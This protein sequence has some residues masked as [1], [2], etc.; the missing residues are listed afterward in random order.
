MEEVVTA[1]L[2]FPV[3]AQTTQRQA[4]TTAPRLL[5]P[6]PALVSPESEVELACCFCHQL[7][8]VTQPTR[9]PGKDESQCKRHPSNAVVGAGPPLLTV[10]CPYPRAAETLDHTACP[11]PSLGITT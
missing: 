7:D 10:A 1:G 9:G 3:S 6:T 2:W 11:K 4:A 5:I 8:S